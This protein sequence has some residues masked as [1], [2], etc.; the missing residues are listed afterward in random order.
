MLWRLRRRRLST[1]SS[2]TAIP[3]L[4]VPTLLPP[5]AASPSSEALSTESALADIIATGVL[6]VGILYNAPPYS[7]L[8]LRG[9]LRGFDVDLLR[10]IAKAWGSEIEF[11]QVTRLNA[12]ERL[13]SGRVHAVATALVRYRDLDQE[14]EFTQTYRQGEQSVLVQS[15][16]VFTSP[17]DLRAAVWVTSLARGRKKH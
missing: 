8:T 16:S 17:L 4:A 3:T 9:E 6:R 2:P 7:E 13:K 5:H 12:L 15:G 14:V 1:R 11:L 10:L